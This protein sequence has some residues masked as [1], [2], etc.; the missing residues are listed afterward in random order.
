[1]QVYSR[2]RAVLDQ[3]GNAVPVEQALQLINQALGE[4]LDEQ[5]GDLDADSRFA[6]TWWEKHHWN[7]ARF[8]E[9]D[10]LARPQGISVDDVIRA[11]VAIYSRP[12]FVRVVGD[13][14]LARD[15]EPSQD[16]RPTAWESVHHLAY[17][18]ID[19]GGVSEAGDLMGKLGALRDQA[20]GLVYRLHAIAA[21]KGWTRD[22][23]RYNALIASWSD[24]LAE[25]GRHHGDRDGLF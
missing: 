16:S 8:G 25:A 1:M 13:G 14:D 2:Y 10:Q 6:V 20:Q 17:R 19:G 22:Q 7:E 11:G 4:V 5:E 24:L 12:G 9:A 15:W 3:A 18:L 21:R 23:E